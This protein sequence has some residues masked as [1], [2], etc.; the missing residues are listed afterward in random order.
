MGNIKNDT[1]FFDEALKYYKKALL[2][3][4]ESS[5]A[6]NNLANILIENGKPEEAE[7]SLRKAIEFSLN[8]PH[9]YNINAPTTVD[10]IRSDALC[11]SARRSPV[12]PSHMCVSCICILT[13][14]DFNF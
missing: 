14:L 6:H 1:C 3:D 8:G 13:V 11:G 7:K 5:V 12:H 10:L 9:Y 2:L 4:N